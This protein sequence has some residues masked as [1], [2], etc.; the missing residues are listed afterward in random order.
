MAGST[1]PYRDFTDREK[2]K[3]KKLPGRNDIPVSEGGGKIPTDKPRSVPRLP[4]YSPPGKVDPRQ[5]TIESDPK[6]DAI[7]RR[8]RRTATAMKTKSQRRN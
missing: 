3:K 4:G 8:L 6:K 1:I 2:Q 5:G 7:R